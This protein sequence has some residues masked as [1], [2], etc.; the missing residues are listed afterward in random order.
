MSLRSVAVG[1]I[2]PETE[3]T[4]AWPLGD[5]FIFDDQ[6]MHMKLVTAFVK[7]TQA[8]EVATYAATFEMAAEAAG[9]RSAREVSG[10]RRL[11]MALAR[12][13]VFAGISACEATSWHTPVM[14]VVMG[15]RFVGK[16]PPSKNGDSP[17][18]WVDDEAGE[19]YLQGWG[20]DPD[21]IAELLRTAGRDH[22]PSNEFVVRFPDRM[23]PLF[24]EI[25]N[26]RR[27]PHEGPDP[28]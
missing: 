12:V 13:S 17:S 14:E 3:R 9:L 24:E 21:V 27:R 15:L 8:S 20:V 2:P 22:I 16:D 6:Q 10:W 11:T 18:L 7:V 4:Q 28:G 1:V 19:C 26:A 23:L 5:F 25:M